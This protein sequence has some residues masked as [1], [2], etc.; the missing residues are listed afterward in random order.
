MRAE[1]DPETLIRQHR[2][3]GLEQLSGDEFILP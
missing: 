2:L 1:I 3:P